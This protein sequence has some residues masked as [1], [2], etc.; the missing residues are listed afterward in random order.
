MDF[1]SEIMQA[2]RK[3][4]EIFQVLKEKNGQTRIPY[5]V[6]TLFRDEEEIKTFSGKGNLKECHQ[7]PTL[8]E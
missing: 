4:H 3:W 7:W 6:K 5:P 2:I 1:S 8:K